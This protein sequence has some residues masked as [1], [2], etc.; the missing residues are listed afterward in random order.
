MITVRFILKNL[1]RKFRKKLNDSL[2]RI[3][4]NVKLVEIL[5]EVSKWIGFNRYFTNASSGNTQKEDE[6]PSIMAALIAIRTNIGLS[7]RQTTQ[8]DLIIINS[9]IFLSGDCIMM[10]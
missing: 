4:P 3:L 1:R 7:K 6:I 8:N 2:Y 9:S 5:F 10:Q